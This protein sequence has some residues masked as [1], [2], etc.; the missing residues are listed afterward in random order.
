MYI[1]HFADSSSI[2]GHLGFIHVLAIVSNATLNMG[3]ERFILITS[4]HAKADSSPLR[5]FPHY[6]LEACPQ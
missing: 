3:V 6:F 5:G 4:I 1:P 2:S